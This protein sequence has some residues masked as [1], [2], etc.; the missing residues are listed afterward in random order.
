MVSF[1]LVGLPDRQGPHQ[2][3]ALERVQD[4]AREEGARVTRDRKKSLKDIYTAVQQLTNI[5]KKLHAQRQRDKTRGIHEKA[6]SGSVCRTQI[7]DIR[8]SF[9]KQHPFLNLNY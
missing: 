8:Y 6:L 5:S 4:K 2:K 3:S 9:Q 1:P 7:N